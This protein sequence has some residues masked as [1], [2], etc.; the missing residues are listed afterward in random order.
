MRRH[1]GLLAGS[2][3]LVVLAAGCR[4]PVWEGPV[5]KSLAASRQFSRQ[6]VIA[7]ESGQWDE[8][9]TLL[10]KAVRSC[11][12]NAEARRHY[13]EVLWHRGRKSEAVAQL[14]QAVDLAGSDAAV[15][16]RLAEMRLALGQLD[17]AGR[18]ID[19]ALNLEPK[20]AAAWAT[21]ARV[22]RAK[23]QPSLALADYYRALGYAPSDRVLLLE[24]A[25]LHREL[26]QPQKALSMLHSLM[27]TQLPG[28]EPQHLLYL[29]GLAQAALGRHDDAAESFALALNRGEPTAELFYLLA[30]SQWHAGRQAEASDAATQALALDG[31]HEPSRRLLEQVGLA[32]RP[33]E[34]LRR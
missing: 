3:L 12:D 5:S 33:D 19:A 8:A 15:R 22:T 11:P 23:G 10:T 9:E 30:E 28:E 31:A 29:Q 26:G 24:V 6:G 27:D 4:L 13:A 34:P 2:A 21:R 7:I 14:Q 17:A 32:E 16:V 18:E 25:E 1:L 20:L